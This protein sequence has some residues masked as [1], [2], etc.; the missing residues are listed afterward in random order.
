MN[1]SSAKFSWKKNRKFHR[2]WE[3]KTRKIF[4]PDLSATIYLTVRK[5]L[6]ETTKWIGRRKAK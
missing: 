5:A 3:R 6:K 1:T 4:F 2:Y